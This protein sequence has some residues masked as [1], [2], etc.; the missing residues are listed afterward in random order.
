MS[1]E[2]EDV[3]E[4]VNIPAEVV[5]AIPPAIPSSEVLAALIEN[6]VDGSSTV[7]PNTYENYSDEP[8]QLKRKRRD[9]RPRI[10]IGAT[11]DA[12]VITQLEIVQN[13]EN[14]EAE[15]HVD[16]DVVTKQEVVQDDT[17]E[18]DDI[19]NLLV[20]SID[21]PSF[22]HIE[23]GGSS[24][25]VYRAERLKQMIEEHD[26]F[27]ESGGVQI[28]LDDMVDDLDEVDVVDSKRNVILLEQD[29]STVNELFVKLIDLSPKLEAKFGSDFFEK[30]EAVRSDIDLGEKSTEEVHPNISV[31]SGN[32]IVEEERDN[33][34]SRTTLF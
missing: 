16:T 28:L 2:G 14:I 6:S 12:S 33:T 27:I 11:V 10:V 21:I 24:G 31:D 15:A 23:A 26:R 34:E 9:P 17:F 22:A 18:K 19:P 3:Y 32:K 7:Q 4:D 25:A 8:L 29:Q 30:S 1:Y 13:K 20:A 5:A